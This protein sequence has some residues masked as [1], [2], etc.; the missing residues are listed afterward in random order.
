MEKFSKCNQTASVGESFSERHISKDSLPERLPTFRE[1]S[2][3]SKK[4]Y[5]AASIAAFLMETA[6]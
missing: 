4:M 5:Q 6:L 1:E 3:L 2:S